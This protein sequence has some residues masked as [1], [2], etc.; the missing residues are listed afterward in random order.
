M[1]SRPSRTFSIPHALR[2]GGSCVDCDRPR[3]SLPSTWRPPGATSESRFE[4]CWR[5]PWREAR[6]VPATTGP[7]AGIGQ[8]RGRHR[9]PRV[10]DEGGL[11]SRCWAHPLTASPKLDAAERWTDPLVSRRYLRSGTISFLASCV[12]FCHECR[13]HR[14]FRDSHIPTTP[15]EFR[16]PRYGLCSTYDLPNELR[17]KMQP[18]STLTTSNSQPQ[19]PFRCCSTKASSGR[20]FNFSRSSLTV[21]KSY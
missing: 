13:G 14:F 2:K 19:P 12:W 7:C 21:I 4:D 3:T 20:Y 18:R 8:L 16:I 1:S 5:S 9:N 15:F 17:E 10:E 6:K 11:W